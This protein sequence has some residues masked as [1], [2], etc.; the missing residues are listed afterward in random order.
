MTSIL[1][2]AETEVPEGFFDEIASRLE[3]ESAEEIA[4][5]VI[6]TCIS[7]GILHPDLEEEPD[8][9]LRAEEMREVFDLLVA[10]TAAVADGT[11]VP[12]LIRQVDVMD[13]HLDVAWER[14]TEAAT[15]PEAAAA[16]SHM[17]NGD[18]EGH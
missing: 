12:R 11:I 4:D 7:R 14:F 8:D 5:V 13:Q 15:D 6:D 16:V 2:Q 1:H 9:D 17:L 10:V 3:T 18:P